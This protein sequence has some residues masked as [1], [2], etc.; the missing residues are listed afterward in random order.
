MKKIKIVCVILLQLLLCQWIG[1]LEAQISVTSFTP[2]S[3]HVGTTVTISGT[4]FNTTPTNNTVFFGATSGVV[5]NAT[6]TT[7]TLKVPSGSTFQPPTV[8]NT[9]DRLSASAKTAFI[10]TFPCGDTI[11]PSSFDGGTGYPAGSSPGAL[12]TGD[13]NGDG[14]PDLVIANIGDSTISILQNVSDPGAVVFAPK[15]DL[16]GK[17]SPQRIIL[18]DINGDGKLDIAVLSKDSNMVTLFKNTRIGNQISF[19][20]KANFATGLSPQNMEIADIDSDGNPDIVVANTGENT[21]SILKN[22]SSSSGGF[23]FI[24]RINF[25]AGNSPQ[26]LAIADIDGD[27][28]VDIVTTNYASG[29]FSAFRNSSVGYAV[30]LDPKIDFATGV[31]PQSIAVADVDKDGMPDMIIANKLSGTLSVIKNMSSGSISFAPKVDVAVGLAPINVSVGDLD[32]DGTPDIAVVNNGSNTISVLKN[33]STNEA[34]SFAPNVDFVATLAPQNLL[35]GDMDGDGRPDLATTNYNTFSV[36]ANHVYAGPNLTGTTTQTICSGTSA[37]LFLTTNTAA[38]YTWVATDNPATT[39]E[40]T[41]SQAGNVIN[42]IIVNTTNSPQTVT[43]YVTPTSTDEFC[44][45][46]PQ[47]VHII[48]NPPP[49][50]NAGTD[51]FLTC[52]NPNLALT[53][54]STTSPVSYQWN[55]PRNT[56]SNSQVITADTAG[57]YVL[58]V[59]NTT[60]LCTNKDS[61][62]VS[63]DTVTP[64]ITCPL[65]Y[66]ITTCVPG[67]ITI[68]GTTDNGSDS[69]KWFG[70]GIPTTNPAVISNQNNYLLWMKRNSNGCIS[71]QTITVTNQII[72]PAIHIPL[73]MDTVPIIPIL[74]TLTCIHDSVLFNFQGSSVNSKIRIIRPSPMNDT[75]LNNTYTELPG[76]YKA[77]IN[78]TSTGCNGNAL[79]FEIKIYVTPPQLIMPPTVPPFNCSFTSVVLNGA[80]GTPNSTLHWTGPSNF[81]SANPATAVLAGDYICSVINP[82]NGCAKSDTLTLVYQPVLFIVG[83]AD[84]TV[85]KGDTVQLNTSPVGGT[86]AFTFSW[87][88]NAG[89]ASSVNVSPLD[90][91]Q[92]IVTVTDAT[93]CIGMDTVFVN[94]PPP[95]RDST[96]TFTLCDSSVANGQLQIIANSGVL[97]Y[98]YSITNGQSFQSSPVFTNLSYGDYPILIQDALHCVH[99]DAATV[100]ALSHKPFPDFIVSTNMMQSDSFVVVDISN[101]RPDTVIWTFPTSVTVVNNNPFAPV[102]VSS[103]TGAV[104]ISMETHFGTC[105]MNVT[106]TVQFIKADTVTAFPNGNGIKSITVFPNPN[107]GQFSVEVKLYKKQTF[108]IYVYNSQGIEQTRITVPNSDY[109]LSTV[110]LPNPIAG[111][112]VLKVI[113]EY[114][115]KSKTIVVTQ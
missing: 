20:L 85:C 79:L 22:Q 19:N 23:S 61:M 45:G 109:N 31:G 99:S 90:T 39:G 93:G 54:S 14:K 36:F 101:P 12:A 37:S 34:I 68:N 73:G 9:F 47:P 21:I 91:T 8:T 58:T 97:P 82:D 44:V 76:I 100:N 11:T 51:M 108:A 103:D 3:G 115:S 71:T 66:Q 43:Y 106:K 62:L 114:D 50:A 110:S 64:V 95:I 59:T 83:N 89:N 81:S 63:F 65:A 41:T 28:R 5:T 2:N 78:D 6:D 56:S 74:D 111:T 86:S 94:V 26:G 67:T 104:S 102:I 55:T 35:I 32:G 87:N 75:V 16:V 18:A 60:T 113:A 17:F 30:A 48:V 49:N 13:L 84:T 15:I 105:I 53:G 42:D 112:Y 96:V 46:D 33:K 10:A 92:Y 69:I 27:Q 77:I 24:P 80:S 40:S 107:T 88:N 38:T 98:Q 52:T 1:V 72:L 4:N 29:S 57:I 25:A 70:S 7:L